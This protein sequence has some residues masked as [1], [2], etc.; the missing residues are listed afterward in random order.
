MVGGTNVY[1][2]LTEDRLAMHPDVG[3]V[4]VIGAPDEDMGEIVMAVVEPARPGMDRDALDQRAGHPL[5]RPADHP[6]AQ[7]M[8][9]H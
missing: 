7:E 9:C 3:D 8:G 1:P 2:Q 5:R 4:A 6:S